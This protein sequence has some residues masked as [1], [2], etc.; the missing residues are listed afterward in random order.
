MRT[1][2]KAAA[3]LKELDKETAFTKTALRRMVLSGE[4]PCVHVGAKRLICLDTLIDRL[5]HPGG[6]FL[7]VERVDG[8]RRLDG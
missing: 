1:I 8:V 4:L 3:E 6:V 7:P 5:Q 2:E